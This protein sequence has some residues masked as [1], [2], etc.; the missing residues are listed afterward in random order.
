MFHDFFDKSPLLL[1]PI[2]SLV[3][4]GTMFVGAVV[5]VVFRG[6]ALESRSLLPLEDE[7]SR[8]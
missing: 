4:F 6:R 8:D 7:V 5:H 2:L 1:W 3:L